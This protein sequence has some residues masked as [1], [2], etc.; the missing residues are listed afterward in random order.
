MKRLLFSVAALLSGLAL[1]DRTDTWSAASV[2]VYQVELLKLSD[3]GCAVQAHASMSKA[4]GGTTTESSA[5]VEVS[6]ANRTTCLDIIDTK[7]PVL[8]K[9]DKGL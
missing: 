4:D 2:K 3:G 8:F 5:V 7:A 9:S 1:A 6:G